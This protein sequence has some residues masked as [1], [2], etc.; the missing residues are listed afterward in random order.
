M[1]APE[2][3][4]QSRGTPFSVFHRCKT[5]SKLGYK[6]DLLVYDIGKTVKI[7]NTCI[8]RSKIPFM[9]IKRVKIGPSIKK[10]FLD[11]FMLLDAL[12]LMLKNKD[13]Y[14]VIHTHEEAGIIG[15]FL[16]IIFRKK[17]LHDMHSS[18]PQ[19]ITNYG[20]MKNNCAVV[21]IMEILERIVVRKSDAIIAICPN[22]GEIARRYD[23]DK[24]IFIIENVPLTEN[25]RNVS[26][27]EINNLKKKLNLHENKVVV[28]TGSLGPQQNIELLINSAKYIKREKG[29]KKI[30]FL[31]VGSWSKE[32]VSNLKKMTKRLKVNDM[33]IFTG[34]KPVEEMP[35]YYSIADILVSPRVAGTN[36]PLKIYSYLNSGKPIVATKVLTH[37]QVLNDEVAI[38]TEPEPKAFA[39][40]ILILLKDK[41]L[42]EELGRNAKRLI[43]KEY[44]YEKYLMKTKRIYEYLRNGLEH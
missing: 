11:F 18:W 3:F 16:K 27:R 42:R 7:K 32:Y 12:T 37:T 24:K 33:F 26:K 25:Y 35:I 38:L 5:L 13:E 8:I 44:S 14:E 41:K 34:Q 28:Y 21:K 9:K 6:I 2:P 29:D 43:E 15:Y 23:K 40:G 36:V 10:I 1:I 31:I 39:E 22:L 30:K 4:F 19:Q 20:F 17:L